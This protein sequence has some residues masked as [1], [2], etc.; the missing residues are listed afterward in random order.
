VTWRGAKLTGAPLD[1]GVYTLR[2]RA[3][4]GSQRVAR[5][6][7]VILD[8]TLGFV[9]VS[10]TAFSPNGDGQLDS[11]EATFTLARAANVQVKVRPRGERAR[12]IFDGAMGAGP[13]TIPWDGALDGATTADGSYTVA[14]QATAGLGTRHVRLPIR[15]DTRRP[16]LSGVLAERT[17]RGTRVRFT[18]DEAGPVVIRFGWKRVQV[19]GTVGANRVW[20][21]LRVERVRLRS[22]DAAGNPSAFVAARVV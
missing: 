10:P 18:L 15:V 8:R 2:F 17:R 21:R 20:R 22:W 5:D 16:T 11:A 13:Q 1:D 7:P 12:V 4:A 19:H 14:V 3:R 6:L 9:T